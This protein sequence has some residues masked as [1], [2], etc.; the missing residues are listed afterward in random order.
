MY[1][2][3]KNSMTTPSTTTTASASDDDKTKISNI[4]SDYFPCPYSSDTSEYIKLTED[5]VREDVKDTKEQDTSKDQQQ[6]HNEETFP[7]NDADDGVLNDN[8][9]DEARIDDK[10][11]I[12]SINGIPYYYEKTLT[13]ARSQMMDLANYFV[14]NLNDTQGAGHLLITDNNLKKVKII[15]PYNF[16]M[17]TYNYVIHEISLEYAIKREGEKGEDE[18]EQE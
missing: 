6:E 13:Q 12:I 15:A 14:G 8:D 5:D 4:D 3:F 16:L 9:T 17:L 18:K 2:L 11:Y 7:D 1:S 10:I